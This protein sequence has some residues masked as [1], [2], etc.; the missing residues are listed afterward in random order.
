MIVMFIC[1]S[2]DFLITTHLIP[3]ATDHGVSA[4]TASNMLA[5]FGL[6][7]LPGVLVAGP[8]ADKVGVKLTVALDFLLRVFIFLLILKYT[9]E[10]SIYTFALAGGFLALLVAPLTP[11]LISNLYGLSQLGLLSGVIT[12][13]HHCGGGFWAF[14]GGVIFDYTGG[15]SFA[16]A[17]SAAMAAL[18]ALCM[19]FV[20]EKRHSAE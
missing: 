7:G 8:I 10:G 17:L 9:D 1:G 14:A 6:M 15:Y 13:A 5:W 16:F 19:M 12:T 18:A 11:L 3:F 20:K 4:I 2:H